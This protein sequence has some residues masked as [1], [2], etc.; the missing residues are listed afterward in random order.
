MSN[1]D[2]FP[3]RSDAIFF[4]LLGLVLAV[5]LMTAL[6]L[7]KAKDDVRSERVRA[8]QEMVDSA[9]TQQQSEIISY[10]A[11]QV[12]GCFVNPSKDPARL[13]MTFSLTPSQYKHNYRTQVIAH[14]EECLKNLRGQ[15]LSS[16]DE[17]RSLI[18]EVSVPE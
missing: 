1:N 10:L 6:P 11:S 3:N 2:T 4:S 17:G 16:T 8:W 5:V 12:P 13:G 14:E 9:P 18:S 15:A 7:L